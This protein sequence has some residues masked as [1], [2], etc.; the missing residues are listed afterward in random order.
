MQQIKKFLKLQTVYKYM[1]I[2]IY[3]YTQSHEMQ[4]G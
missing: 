4:T 3:N 1:T 2:T